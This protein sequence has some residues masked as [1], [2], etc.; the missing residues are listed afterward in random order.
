[1]RC[2]YDVER[3]RAKILDAGLAQNFG[4]RLLLGV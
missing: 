1:V 2:E 3:Q 4:T